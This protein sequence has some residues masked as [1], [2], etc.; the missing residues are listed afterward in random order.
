MLV[1]ETEGEKRR[2]ASQPGDQDG[3][4]ALTAGGH[5]H[6]M[7]LMGQIEHEELRERLRWAVA[8]EKTEED[9]RDECDVDD[10]VVPDLVIDPRER[11]I[12]GRKGSGWSFMRFA[13][14]AE[15]CPHSPDQR[16]LVGGGESGEDVNDGV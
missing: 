6:L 15:V 4:L 8:G 1:A 10:V 14:P 2:Q 3:A 12:L 11:F 5:G 7:R 16:D 13:R 9:G